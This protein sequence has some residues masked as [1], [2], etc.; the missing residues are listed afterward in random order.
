MHILGFGLDWQA[1]P[2]VDRLASMQEDRRSRV[3][4][5]CSRLADEGVSLDPE[6]VFKESGGVTVGRKHVA[7]ALHR[8][9][10]VRSVDDAFRKFLG[11]DGPANVPAGGLSTAEA[12]GLIAEYGGIPVLA[13]PG[14]LDDDSKVEAIL[15]GAP[16]RGIEVFHRYRSSTKHLVYLEMARRRNLLITG[17]SDFHGDDG[18][19][20]APLGSHLC[21]AVHWKA[22]ERRLGGG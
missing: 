17:G 7:R 4:E 1:K 6:D 2:L 5:I 15:N 14:F 19:R 8:K 20:N 18:P 10:L 3:K 11:A 21:P 16:I 13:H 12:A 9:G 22:L